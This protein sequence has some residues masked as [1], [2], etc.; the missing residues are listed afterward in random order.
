[1]QKAA[2]LNGAG[3]RQHADEDGKPTATLLL[4]FPL[5]PLTAG[6]R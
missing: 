2:Q 5:Y 4:L 6:H 1:M 3:S